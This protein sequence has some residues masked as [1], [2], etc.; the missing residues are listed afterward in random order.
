MDSVYMWDVLI[1]S[2]GQH[3]SECYLF[4]MHLRLENASTK[5]RWCDTVCAVWHPSCR[6]ILLTDG[7]K[8]SDLMCYFLQDRSFCLQKVY[9]G[10]MIA[11]VN[12]SKA[13]NSNPRRSTP[14]LSC[15]TALCGCSYHSSSYGSLLKYKERQRKKGIVSNLK[16]YQSSVVVR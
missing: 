6:E 14:L 9:E 2:L 16:Q 10:V 13:E 3:A 7:L 11:N 12:G 15:C 4:H 5:L 8:V 1:N